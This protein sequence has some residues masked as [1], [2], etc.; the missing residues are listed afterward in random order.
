MNTITMTWWQLR[1]VCNE[2]KLAYCWKIG[3][4]VSCRQSTCP[5]WRRAERRQGYVPLI[6]RLTPKQLAKLKAGMDALRKDFEARHPTAKPMVFGPVP[7]VVDGKLKPGK[8][9]VMLAK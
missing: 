2:D 3:A 5:I 6:K 1:G 9:Y 4:H 7:T 8:K